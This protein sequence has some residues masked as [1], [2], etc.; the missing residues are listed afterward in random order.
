MLQVEGSQK[1]DPQS[2]QAHCHCIIIA[3]RTD[4]VMQ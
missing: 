1:A 3:V 2:W 4:F